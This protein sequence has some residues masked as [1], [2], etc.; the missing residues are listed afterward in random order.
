MSY[1][2]VNLYSNIPHDL[3]IQAID[4]WLKKY[5]M[6][7]HSRIK[8]DFILEGIQFILKNNTFKFNDEFYKQVKGTAMGTKCAPVYATLV[9]AYLEET[10]YTEVENA[11]G[12]DFK[13]YFEENWKRFL[14]DCFLLFNRS[15][16]EHQRLQNILNSLHPC[17]Q[18]TCE[19]SKTRLSFLDTM[20]IKNGKKLETDIYYKPTDSKQYLLYSSCHPKHTRNNIPYSLARRL[21]AIVSDENVLDLRMKELHQSLIKRGYPTA[22][23]DDAISIATRMN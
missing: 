15:E 3:G 21:R 6:L 22:V 8:P 14:D 5:P 1:D 18:F 20:V 9:L 10:L 23:I 12:S 4:Y 11:F 19:T 2:V 7:L 13:T 16:V 17:I